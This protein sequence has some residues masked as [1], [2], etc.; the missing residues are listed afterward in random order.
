M[1][2]RPSDWQFI[3]G[4][5]EPPARPERIQAEPLVGA[6]TPPDL[7]GVYYRGTEILRRVGVRVRAPNWGT[8]PPSIKEAKV[9]HHENGVDARFQATHTAD[10]ISFSWAGT[11]S[12]SDTALTYK[13]DA[14]A[15]RAF[16]YARIG[17]VILHPPAVTAGRT[18]HARR[19]RIC[20]PGVLPALVGPQLVLDGE[21]QPLFPAFE[22]L[23]IELARGLKLLI[24]LDGEVFEMEDQRNWTDASFKTYSTPV[25]LPVPH[26][27]E[28]GA[29]FH[30]SAHFQILDSRRRGAAPP[31]RGLSITLDEDVAG[32]LVPPLG[33]GLPRGALALTAEESAAVAALR[34]AHL[35]LELRP[36]DSLEQRL[37][38]A[39][40]VASHSGAEIEL[41][42]V[43]PAA[44]PAAREWLSGVAAALAAVDCTP[45][46]V[47]LS[48][49][50]ESVT[51]VNTAQL[52]RD[53]LPGITLLGGSPTNFAELNRD[54]PPPEAPLDGLFYAANP[55]VHD[56]DDRAIMQSP[57]AQRDTVLTARR[58]PGARPIHVSPITLVPAAAD[59]P[60]P[61][62]R[63]LFTAAWLVSSATAVI[64]AGVSSVTWF[65]LTGPHCLIETPGGGLSPS[66]QVLRELGPWRGRATVPVTPTDP[67]TVSAL[68]IRDQ[69]DLRML[70]SNLTPAALEVEVVGVRVP[71]EVG[72]LDARGAR[73]GDASLGAPD[74]ERIDVRGPFNLALGPYAVASLRRTSR[75][76][77]SD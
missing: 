52:A 39:M 59:R 24:Q 12:V 72:R 22:E 51:T 56:T 57:S 36:D 37:S 7:A 77:G 41:A 46:R 63:S 13:M 68:A 55:Q 2:F 31:S 18:F 49:G 53:H 16:P 32:P 64:S 67:D 26:H 33:I 15:E 66:Y 5:P 3:L 38:R 1:T 25:G 47:A 45:V 11:I 42:L 60:D 4:R 20:T 10:A 30:Q 48:R 62:Q 50:G 9:Q 43:L 23:E 17:I 14:V 58:L 65:E 70:V 74:P 61:R 44:E 34:P 19:G 29:R 6:L 8:V 73:R 35:R 71:V 75:A 54:P 28:A 76:G 21:V 69:D 40:T 27:A